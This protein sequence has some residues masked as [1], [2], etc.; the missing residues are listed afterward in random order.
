LEELN[1]RRKKQTR[2]EDRWN[3]KSEM[4]GKRR[5]EETRGKWRRQME[6]REEGR[7]ER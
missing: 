2:C 5:N 6:K 7:K 4:E 1:E 3:G